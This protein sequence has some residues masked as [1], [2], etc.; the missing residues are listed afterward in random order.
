MWGQVLCCHLICSSFKQFVVK[1]LVFQ[2]SFVFACHLF[3]RGWSEICFYFTSRKCICVMCFNRE[4]VNTVNN[5]TLIWEYLGPVSLYLIITD[6]MTETETTPAL[7]MCVWVWDESG[8]HMDRQKSSKHGEMRASASYRPITTTMSQ[9][10]SF[11]WT[12]GP[13][14]DQCY[15]CHKAGAHN[16]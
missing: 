13:Q 2:L 1:S 8:W 11:K 5:P 12:T 10:L 7:C 4:H 9:H 6:R 15:D 14:Q 3:W 16:S